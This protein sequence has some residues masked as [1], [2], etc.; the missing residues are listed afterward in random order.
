M[1]KILKS[2][3]LDSTKK[4]KEL[5]ILESITKKPDQTQQELAENINI[6]K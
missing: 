4:L 2:S 1:V 3:F 6:S 5:K